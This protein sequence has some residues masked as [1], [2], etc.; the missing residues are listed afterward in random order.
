M[1]P[2]TLASG[3]LPLT[4]AWS[5]DGQWLYFSEADENEV[6]HLYR[7]RSVGGAVERVAIDTWDWAQG[8]ARLRIRTEVLTGQ[9]GAEPAPARLNVVDATGHPAVPDE[10]GIHFDGTNGRHFFYS[11][12]EI[13][14]TV[15]AGMVTVAAVQGLATPEVQVT[16]EAKAG[17]VTDV[18]L[19]LEPV[20][21]AHA[22]GWTS[23]D[24][25]FHLNYGGQTDLDPWDMVPKMQGEALDVATPLLANLHNRI[26]D[27]DY[28][29]WE[30]LDEPP[31]IRFGQ[32]IRSH[33]LGHVGPD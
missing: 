5:T 22:A 3:G 16:V 23:G 15:P 2:V 10:G 31:F 19:V 27:Q 8:T 24:H 4:P 14:I 17:V 21:D 11:P 20:W 13:E 18:T 25:H 26:E 29:G 30:K 33:F 6:M 12:G 9:P 32:E 1:A 28:W 7:I